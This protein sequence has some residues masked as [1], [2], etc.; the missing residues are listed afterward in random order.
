M[1]CKAPWKFSWS[2]CRRRCTRAPSRSVCP[3]ST[4][5]FA[6]CAQSRR[7]LT[8]LYRL[9]LHLP[10]SVHEV[11][12]EREGCQ[13]S[14]HYIAPF[15]HGSNLH[16]EIW[17]S[18]NDLS[19]FWGTFPASESTNA[20][21]RPTPHARL[22]HSNCSSLNSNK[23]GKRC[24]HRR[25]N[26]RVSGFASARKTLQEAF[27]RPLCFGPLPGSGPCTLTASWVGEN[28]HRTSRHS[29]AAPR[30]VI[31]AQPESP[32]LSLELAIHP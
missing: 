16:P 13:N 19:Y 17:S 5:M 8:A 27:D 9:D 28:C 21:F 24:T 10:D 31:L 29:G 32:Y 1:R 15:A 12:R 20:G 6:G 3:A 7:T 25:C 26:P 18:P 11:W 23:A 2:I 30:I 22:W 14:I 4:H